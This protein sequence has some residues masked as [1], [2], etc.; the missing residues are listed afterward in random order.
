[1]SVIFYHR[2]KIRKRH[3]LVSAFMPYLFI[4]FLS[5][6]LLVVTVI[7]GM[8]QVVRTGSITILGQQRSLDQVSV[9]L[10]YPVG[11]TGEML[12]LTAIYL[13]MPVGG[14]SL[15][16][17]FIGGATATLLWEGTRH[18]LIW[19]YATMSQIQVVYG[20]LTTAVGVLVAW[21]LG[22]R[23]RDFSRRCA[24]WLETEAGSSLRLAVNVRLDLRI[25]FRAR[26][27]FR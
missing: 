23:L 4:L 9:F 7:S 14:L 5:V 2:V 1:M 19:Y 13:I 20:S 21:H 27:R 18:I 10:L 17:A 12:L 8:L 11:L 24:F 3:I 25:P 6:G 15:C 16:H 22:V 26:P